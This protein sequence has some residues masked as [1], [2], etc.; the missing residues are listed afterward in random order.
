MDGPEGVSGEAPSVK[1]GGGNVVLSD[2]VAET[3]G[4]Q[5]DF[6]VQGVCD[7]RLGGFL[8]DNWLVHGVLRQYA[9]GQIE[10]VEGLFAGHSGTLREN[11]LGLRL[12]LRD[13]PLGV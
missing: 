13:L 11:Q 12:N 10:V 7:I 8:S 5:I 2:H 6:I 9:A 1:G 3:G 4:H